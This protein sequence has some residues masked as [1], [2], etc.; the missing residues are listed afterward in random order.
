VALL[1]LLAT[2]V[3]ASPAS[4]HDVGSLLS[5]YETRL[6]SVTPEV[7][8]ID[9]AV[10]EG[11]NRL[12]ARNATDTDLV[13]LGYEDEP[14]LRIGPDGA[15]ENLNSPA[16]YLNADREATLEVPERAADPDVAPEWRKIGDE[17]LARW[18]DHR[19][20]WMSTSDPAVVTA[21]PDEEHVVIPDWV[22]PM[23]H[24][25][26]TIEV[27]G[28]LVWRPSPSPALPA[29]VILV[30]AGVVG[31]TGLLASWRLWSAIAVAVLMIASTV[32]ALGVGFFSVGST[33]ERLAESLADALYLP[34]LLVGGV[35]TIVLLVR[36]HPFAPYLTV[37]TGA[38]GG[39]FGGILRA[40][41]LTNSVLPT[42]LS[43]GLARGLVAL[44]LGLGLGLLGAGI[45]AITRTP[46]APRPP[47]TVSS[48]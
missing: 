31:A 24:G 30:V 40:E 19:V 43:A 26:Q 22:V 1:G 3:A 35:A 33:G 12:E 6:T 20:H 2:V 45:V 8:G 42:A 9:V 16:T 39:L 5:N 32:S 37:F 47:E 13:V 21:A 25:D 7:E 38:V 44:S 28:D 10:I 27:V 29:V 23:V 46:V 48:A 34:F 15:F 11:G 36:R 17:P 14:Y 18:H 41:M 4:A